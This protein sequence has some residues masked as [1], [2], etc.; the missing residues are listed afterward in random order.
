MRKR[1]TRSNNEK[2]I[3]EVFEDF[4]FHNKLKNLAPR[5]ISS[6]DKNTIHFFNFLEKQNIN[7]CSELDKDVVNDFI[8]YLHE[9]NIKDV[10]INTYLRHVRAFLYY[11]M[12]E[13]YI[14]SFKIHLIKTNEEQKAP[15]TEDEIKRLLSPPNFRKCGFVEWR[16]WLMVAYM[17][18]TGNRLNTVINL[19]IENIDFD[20]GL[21]ILTSN[22]NR[23]IN[24]SPLSNVMIKNIQRFIE[25]WGLQEDDYLFP[26]ETGEK[27]KTRAVQSS[28][29]KYN[30]SRGVTK[31]GIHRFRHTFAKNYI[32]KGG[33]PLVLQKLLHHS[34]LN[35]TQKYVRLYS[36]DLKNG[37]SDISIVE[38]MTK[39]QSFNRKR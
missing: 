5:T 9:L 39:N 10:S 37:F 34:T 21:I 35:I 12:N 11:C 31:T 26:S 30:H 6:Y 4:Q 38:N 7:Y 16:N 25:T 2:T 36:N 28:I 33:N 23:Q 17:L 13:E 15:Y 29:S 32:S 20:N 22:K 18:E 3:K 8:L 1:F 14:N 27:M 19:K 24:Y